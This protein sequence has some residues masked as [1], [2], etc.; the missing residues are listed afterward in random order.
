MIKI[1]I[2]IPCRNE[3]LYIEECIHAIY[4][5]EVP[6]EV[7][8]NVF[9]VD[10]MSNDGTRRIIQQL[11][12]EF[13]T[14]KIVDNVQQLTPFAFNLGIHATSCDYVQIIGARHIISKNYLSVCLQKLNEDSSI[15]CVGGRL[16]NEYVNETGKVIALAM[17]TQLGMGIGNFRTLSKSGFTDTVTSPMYPYGVFEKIGFFDEELIRNQDDDFNF[18]VTQAGGKIWFDA[19]ISLKY[20]VRGNYK[21]L[22]KQFYQYGYW[23]V[24]VNRKHRTFTT[25]R[26]LIPPLFV[27]YLLLFLF[28]WLFGATVGV[29]GSFPLIVYLALTAI[30]TNRL[31]QQ[32]HQL[33]FGDIF[34]TF[35]ILH[36]SYGL[37]YLKGVIDFVLL[38][39]KP[40]DKQKQMSR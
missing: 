9:V 18:R 30:T 21:N 6:D 37:G 2:V 7:K 33:R 15:W 26:Q 16:E 28:T 35:S 38:N 3:A 27:M 19:D 23:K 40:S 20:Y 13:L 24:Y 32:D 11:Q 5:A 10:G 25:V 14:L 39:K 4:A 12:E 22:W 8:I 1:S 17:G 29:A 34:K 36:I 31:V